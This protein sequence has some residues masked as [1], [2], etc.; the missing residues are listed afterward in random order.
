M[1][2]VR[3]P[4]LF[5][6]CNDLVSFHCQ[7]RQAGIPWANTQRQ[8]YPALVKQQAIKT[9]CGWTCSSEGMKGL[10]QCEDMPGRGVSF[11][12]GRTPCV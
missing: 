1:Q 11:C 7:L 12:L 5:R 4:C 8:Q 10:A 2:L 9:R 6:I 3:C